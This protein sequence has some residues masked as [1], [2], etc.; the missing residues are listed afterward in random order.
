MKRIYKLTLVFLLISR[1]G[2]AQLGFGPEVGMGISTMHFA[3]V[4]GFTSASTNP[5]FAGRIG[6]TI[7]NSL[8][9]HFYYQVGLFFTTRG[10]KRE[11]AFYDN[12]SSN[13]ATQQTIHLYYLDLP[14]NIL[15][16]TGAQGRP[17]LFL[18]AGVTL[19]YLLTGQDKTQS[20]GRYNDT[21]FN[22]NNS[23]TIIM[24]NNGWPRYDI[25]INVT[26]GLEL[27]TGLFFRLYYTAGI[28]DIGQNSEIDKN[29]IFGISA[30]YLFGKGR[31]VNKDTDDLID[32]GHD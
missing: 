15:F 25:G 22:V 27:P 5:I 14:A 10:Q 17:R 9:K 1:L 4:I 20:Q 6:G 3:P 18:G 19:S 24:G 28:E 2:F 11:Y 32:K 12:D 13:D 29:R 16:K 26:A 23:S 31:N 7:D 21:A 30:G 8:N